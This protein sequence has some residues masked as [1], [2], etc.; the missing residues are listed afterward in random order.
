MNKQMNTNICIYF[1]FQNFNLSYLFLTLPPIF[2][3]AGTPTFRGNA[4][5]KC[6]VYHKLL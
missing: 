3:W 1:L 6:G 5:V 2:A 4:F